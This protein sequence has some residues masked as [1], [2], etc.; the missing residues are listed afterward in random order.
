MSQNIKENR[1][2]LCAKLRSGNITQCINTLENDDGHMCVMGVANF[3]AHGHSEYEPYT[4]PDYTDFYGFDY[5]DTW[6][7]AEKNN[8]GMSF[9]D[10]ANYIE[11]MPVKND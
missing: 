9:K 7:L 11:N 4:R 8:N 2:K 6:D 10:L 1:A 3:V 5:N